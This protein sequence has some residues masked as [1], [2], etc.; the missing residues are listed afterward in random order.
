M[1][2]LVSSTERLNFRLDPAIKRVIERA[3]TIKGLSITDFAIST[4]KREAR[5]IVQNDETLVLSDRDRDAFLAALD[6]PPAA[7]AKLRRAAKRYKQAVGAGRI[8]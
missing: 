8:K 6:N 4:L 3:A 2:S 7:G 5:D 1:T